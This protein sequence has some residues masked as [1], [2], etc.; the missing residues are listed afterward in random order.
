MSGGTY[1]PVVKVDQSG[2][3][4]QWL[5]DGTFSVNPAGLGAGTAALAP[6]TAPGTPV[7]SGTWEIIKGTGGYSGTFA[8]TSLQYAAGPPPKSYTVGTTGNPVD[9]FTL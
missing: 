2:M 3:C 6:G 8:A 9:T 5:A 7:N 4:D 1:R